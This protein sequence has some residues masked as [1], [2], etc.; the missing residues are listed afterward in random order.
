MIDMRTVVYSYAISNAIC[1]LVMASLWLQSRRR[2]AGIGFWMADF[3]MQLMGIVLIALRGVV[4]DYLSILASNTL[5]VLGTILLFMGLEQFVGKPGSQVQNYILLATFVLIQTYLTYFQADMQARTISVTIGVF[6]VCL[7]CAWLLLRRV[8][9][10]MRPITREVGVLMVIFCLISVIRIIIDLAIPPEDR[11]FESGLFDTLAILLYQMFFIVLTFGLFLMVNRRL[12]TDLEQDIDDHQRV[13]E[14]LRLSEEKFS[15]A[16]RSSPDAILITRARDGQI[17]EVNEGFSRLAGYSSEEALA[18]SSIILGLWADPQERN[19]L[20]ESL[21]EKQTPR[22][23]PYNF[24]TRSGDILHCL[25]SGEIIQLNGEAHV[26]SVIRDVTEQKQTEDALRYQNKVMTALNHVMLAL[27]DRHEIDD[28]LR[29]L[30]V[31]IRAL[32][33]APYISID[34]VDHGDTLVTYAA[35]SGQPLQIGDTMR[36]GEGGWLS[37]QAIDSKQPAVLE[38]YSTWSKRRSLYNGFPI[39]A[40]L[41]VPILQGDS[42]VGAI[43]FLRTETDKPFNDTDIHAAQQL[44]QMVA[45]VLDNA[46]LLEQLQT[47]LNERKRAEGAVSKLAAFEERQNLARELHDSVN[48]SIHSLVLF[49]ETLTATLEKNH[50][51]RARQI[52]LRLQESARQ[53]LKETRLMLYE[54]QPSDPERRVDLVP[55]LETRLETVERRAGVRAHITLEGSLEHLPPEW[56]ENLFWIVIEALNNAL[57]HAQARSVQISICS[58]PPHIE[59]NVQ[60]NGIGFDPSRPQIGGFGLRNMSERAGLLGGEL[61]FDSAP[62]KGTC[63]SF[64]AEITAN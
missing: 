51:D 41:I 35:T 24:R 61:T 52:A 64:V 62:G 49:S 58:S 2:Y 26:L 27:V 31:E 3:A 48:Q 40:V 34:L 25:Y 8:D 46:E 23:V 55:D 44:A 32:L 47:E 12:V 50:V 19:T 17:V 39:H 6:L 56:N 29:T 42:V 38:D 18:S 10:V 33:D 21:K 28:I 63:V 60:D 36:R 13:E 54:L 20:I 59:L 30:L 37:W 16:F 7:E 14:A 15:K 43:N 53:A 11:F 45:L 57:K 22:D 4:P 1:V 9:A 5:I